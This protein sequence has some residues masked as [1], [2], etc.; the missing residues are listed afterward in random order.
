[1]LRRR[2]RHGDRRNFFFLH[3]VLNFLNLGQIARKT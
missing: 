2:A 3:G 1:L